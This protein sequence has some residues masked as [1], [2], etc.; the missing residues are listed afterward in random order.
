VSVAKTPQVTALAAGHPLAQITAGI[1]LANAGDA[2]GQAF[3]AASLVELA[4]GNITGAASN[5][6]TVVGIGAIASA[7]GTYL[8]ALAAG[9]RSQLGQARVYITQSG[10]IVPVHSADVGTFTTTLQTA[11]NNAANFGPIGS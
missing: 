5:G 6:L 11:L 9:K 3:A 8:G 4:A 2:S 1:P 10:L 7:V